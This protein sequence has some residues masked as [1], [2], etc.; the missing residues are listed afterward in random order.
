MIFRIYQAID[1]ASGIEINLDK[2]A[3]NHVVNVLR[4]KVNDPL[5]IF[6]EFA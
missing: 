3:V 6:N 1:L 4:L 5:I 2:A